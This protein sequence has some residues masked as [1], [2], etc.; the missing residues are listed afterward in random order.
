MTEIVGQIFGWLAPLFT[1]ISYQCKDRKQLLV[2]QSAS[3]VSLCISYLLLG[4]CSGLAL[5]LT[6]IVRNYVYISRR[7]RIF[8]WKGWPLVLA[9]A[10]AVA[11]T[12]SWEGP[13]SL[14]IIAALVI[15]TLFL[16]ADNVQNL[17]KSIL[18]TSTMVLIYNACL[19][20]W[21]G[22]LNELFAFA[23]AAVG[24]IRFKNKSA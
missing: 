4:A 14:V 22:V 24:I 9:A 21:G 10:M 1:I 6:A 19:G 18:L 11:G 17:R 23:S 2:M 8:S 20:I 13:I 16:G 15:N 12:A 5:N 3:T 7:K